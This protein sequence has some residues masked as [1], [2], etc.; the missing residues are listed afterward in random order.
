[1][2]KTADF[3]N[4][5]SISTPLPQEVVINAYLQ[6]YDTFSGIVIKM[7]N[8]TGIASTGKGIAVPGEKAYEFIDYPTVEKNCSITIHSAEKINAAYM[9]SP[10]FNEIVTCQITDAGKDSYTIASPLLA[11]FGIL[12]CT[13]RNDLVKA[14]APN[15]EYTDQKPQIL[16]FDYRYISIR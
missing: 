13:T 6:K 10:D 7:L 3:D 4:L 15:G 5:T 11:R 2:L 14:L 16:P 1:M 12:Y 8:L 9:I